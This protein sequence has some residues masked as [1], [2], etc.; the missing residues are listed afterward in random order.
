MF[1]SVRKFIS[2]SIQSPTVFM[3]APLDE[4]KK[5]RLA[6][7]LGWLDDILKGRTW[8][9]DENFTVADLSIAVTV[10]QIEAYEFDLG[11][12]PRIRTWLQKC[13]AE[14]HPYGYE[15]AYSSQ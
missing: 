10:S 11:P 2:I 15:V 6:E 7:A 3:G 5:A 14:L 13:K 9:A 1:R 12:Y 8:L 4:T